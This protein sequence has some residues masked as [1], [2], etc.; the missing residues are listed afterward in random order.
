LKRGCDSLQEPEKYREE[1]KTE[2]K[3]KEKI[4]A[5]QAETKKTLRVKN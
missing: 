3:G 5:Q 4:K 1:T 2:M